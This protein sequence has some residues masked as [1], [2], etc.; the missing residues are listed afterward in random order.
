MLTVKAHDGAELRVRQHG[1]VEGP[2]VLVSHG[3]GFATDGYFPFWRH[4]LPHCEVLVYDQR[5]HGQNPL[6]RLVD[7]GFPNFVRDL[8]ALLAAL[9]EAIGEKPPYGVFHSLSAIVAVAHA[10]EHP[11]PWAGLVLFDPP[12][13]PDPSDPLHEQARSEE[14]LLSERAA[15]RREEFARPEDLAEKLA[16]AMPGPGWVPGAHLGLARAVLRERPE[17]GFTLACPADFESKVF[18]DNS[19]NNLCPRLGELPGPVL[20]L[21]GDPEG[22]TALVPAKVNRALHERFGYPYEAPRGT[23]HM[24]MLEEPELCARRVLGFFGIGPA[25]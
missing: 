12:F 19:A 21:C 23:S 8:D 22:P 7:H 1:R 25:R 9:P 10:L 13:C 11:W 4:L 24:L 5:N 16:G 6:H 17:G 20:F 3:N 14:G 18:A 2:R 15:R